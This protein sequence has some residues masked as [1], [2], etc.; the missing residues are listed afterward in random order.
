MRERRSG[1]VLS[2][3][4]TGSLGVVGH[5][6]AEASHAGPLALTKTLALEAAPQVLYVDGGLS[7]VA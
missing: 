6:S 4:S 5:V 2:V 7:V 1:R 3:S